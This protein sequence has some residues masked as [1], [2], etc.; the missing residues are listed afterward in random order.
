MHL[1]RVVVP[2]FDRQGPAQWGPFLGTGTFV[3]DPPLLATAY[4][5]VRDRG[6]HFG[7]SLPGSPIRWNISAFPATLIRYDSAVDLALLRVDG[8]IPPFTFVLAEPNEIAN[9]IPVLSYEYGTTVNVAGVDQLAPATRMGNVTRVIDLSETFGL[10]GRHALELSYPALRG[11]S[12]A[13]VVS[14]I[15]THLWGVIV[16]NSE[17]HLLPVQIESV[18]DADGNLREDVRYMLP[19]AIAVNVVHLRPL[20][21]GETGTAA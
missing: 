4:H 2:I 3:G 19:Q 8:Y 17:Y 1:F 15:N 16:A 5:V 13:P 10:A 14:S 9:N 18:L 7:I 11:A 12:G 20:L 6:T 21:S